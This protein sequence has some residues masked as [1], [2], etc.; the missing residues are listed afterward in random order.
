[1]NILSSSPTGAADPTAVASTAYVDA[2]RTVEAQLAEDLS[3]RAEQA[4]S[5]AARDVQAYAVLAAA[6]T[7]FAL[8]TAYSVGRSIT[9]PLHRLA[10]AATQVATV[11]L[12]ALVE[13]L[14][15]PKASTEIEFTPIERTSSDEIGDVAEAFAEIQR[16]TAQVA[17]EQGALLRKGI[18]DLFVNLA[19]RNQSLLDRQIA[20]LDELEASETDPEELEHLFKLDHLATRMRR[21]AESL[22]VLAGVETPRRW[23]RPVPVGDVIRAAISE[24]E[25]Y[26]RI[27]VTGLEDVRIPGAAAADVAHL[28]AELLD[29]A[30]QFSP[31]GS[32]VE[33]SGHQSTDQGGGYVVR[34]GDTGI[35]M[36]A[37]QLAEANSTLAEP[38]L[39]GLSLSRSLGFTVVS[40]LAH[41]YGI[42]VTVTSTSGGG[43]TTIAALPANL[44]VSDG[45]G[46][47]ASFEPDGVATGPG[48]GPRIG[49]K[50]WSRPP[51]V[52]A[53]VWERITESTSGSW[54]DAP[55][56]LVPAASP[57]AL[58]EPVGAFASI[59]E[60]PL[61]L[62][63][64]PVVP[65]GPVGPVDVPA[66]L[67]EA[68]P[69][70]AEVSSAD[71]DI[72]P[73]PA[74]TTS[75][76]PRRRPSAVPSGDPLLAP[77]VGDSP[78]IPPAPPAARPPSPRAAAARSTRPSFAP[79]RVAPA[80]RSTRPDPIPTD[81]LPR[82]V[83]QSA[84]SAAP[85]GGPA[86]PV[87]ATASARTPEEIRS[88][89]SA[90]RNGI[91]RG[92]TTHPS[93]PRQEG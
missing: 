10:T 90:Y 60:G 43:V 25:D 56:D 41:R 75:G 62:G 82:R 81:G 7:L 77:P 51:D 68:L 91:A 28:F 93:D 83:A 16:V 15:T 65:A 13:T 38:P 39:T 40:R 45:D 46:S 2:L 3:H 17:A 33:V 49:P 22:L 27:Q 31:P 59:P 42:G 19:R 8:L 32:E 37:A 57:Y 84:R 53:A 76:L 85:T 23:G 58:P 1:M 14:R 86:A 92:R 18:G 29:N 44:L 26:G 74:T 69:P 70:P 63:L 61:G 64:G 4:R 36:S 35:G 48:A 67:A 5:D 71:A 21:N 72:E 20:Y 24:V 34:I 50:G 78:R 73:V 9:Q 88:M 79:E 54:S 47:L 11:Q 12:P 52:P 80:P 6:A 66:T 55:D 30:T 87:G 89:L